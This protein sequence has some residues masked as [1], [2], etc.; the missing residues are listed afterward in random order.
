MNKPLKILTGI[1][2]GLIGLLLV[3][4]FAGAPIVKNYVNKHSQEILGRDLQIDKV[5]INPF[6]G[7]V[8]LQGVVCKEADG[9]T[10]F[11]SFEKLKVR[12]RYLR[13]I[14]KEV[15]ISK[16]HLNELDAKLAYQDGTFNFSDIIEHFQKDTTENDT[17]PS[18]WSVELKDIRILQSAISYNTDTRLEDINLVVPGLYFGNQQSAAGLAF[19]LPD[20]GG[21]VFIKGQYNVGQS[22]YGLNLKLDSVNTDIILPFIGDKLGNNCIGARVYGDL[23]FAGNLNVIKDINMSGNIELKNIHYAN[24]EET[25]SATA[26]N[27]NVT[28]EKGNLEAMAFTLQ[29]NM[30]NITYN[31]ETMY[32]PFV[33]HVDQ[34]SVTANDLNMNGSS[35]LRARAKIQD[36]GSL[37]AQWNGPLSL[38][39]G[40]SKATIS[41]KNIQTKPFSPYCEYFFAYPIVAGTLNLNSETSLHNGDLNSQNKIDLFK[42]EVGKKNKKLKVDNDIPLKLCISLLEDVNH[43]MS[44][45]VP[46]T[47]NINEPKFSFRQIIGTAIGNLLLNAVAAPFVAMAKAS[48]KNSAVK[49]VPVDITATDITVEQYDALDQI[50]DMMLQHEN[51][52]LTLTQNFRLDKAQKRYKELRKD[53]NPLDDA[54][55]RN[56]RIYNYLTKRKGVS[57]EQL[58]ITTMNKH[59][60]KRYI[61]KDKYTLSIEII[62]DESEQSIIVEDGQDESGMATETPTDSVV[63]TDSIMPANEANA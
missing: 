28:I 23:D 49:N 3:V 59:E 54:E 8:V 15:L 11:V 48:N 51:L 22:A 39:S 56:Q 21:S 16:I 17:T 55:L 10:D 19:N 9:E 25:V 57:E 63:V 5:R 52:H 6:T 18:G 36:G 58:S 43:K 41:L 53:T 7:A 4:Q 46:V 13:L 40:S 47:G 45:E 1:G 2:A 24:G 29:A 60:L 61:G 33:Y 38:S 30:Q 37:S 42:L 26:D 31:D 62:G 20:E 12:C 14:G 27:L 50:A 35:S 34:M 32:S 44:L